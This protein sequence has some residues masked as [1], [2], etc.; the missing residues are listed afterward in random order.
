MFMPKLLSMTGISLAITA[1][2]YRQGSLK[3]ESTEGG[4]RDG[5]AGYKGPRGATVPVDFG[6]LAS[7][8]GLRWSC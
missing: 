2:A 5:G 8:N 4:G 7:V 6:S 1:F 3:P